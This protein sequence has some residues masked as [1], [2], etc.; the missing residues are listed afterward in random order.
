MTPLYVINDTHC[1]AIRS[2]GTTPATAYALRT[3]ILERFQRLLARARG[4]HLMILGDLFDN[5]SVPYPDLLEVYLMLQDFEGPLILVPGNHDLSK[6]TAT[7]S[8][9][10]FLCRLLENRPETT[11]MD[12]PGTLRVG[13][14]DHYVIPHVPN[15]ELFDLELS[16]VPK[17][18][19][20]LFLH[21]NF[22]NKFA[23]QADH[24]LNLS[25]EQAKALPVEKIILA[26]EHQRKT[27]LS[28]KVMIPGNQ[29]PSSV[30]D[31]L[32][33]DQKFMIEIEDGFRMVPVWDAAG[34]FVRADWHDLV[35]V[36]PNAQFIRVEGQ[37]SASEAASTV[38]LIQKLRS[39]HKAFVITNAI[40]V[41]GRDSTEEKLTLEEIRSYNVLDALLKRLKPEWQTKVRKLMENNDV[42][43]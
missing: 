7:M 43:R 30:A 36:D 25:V 32:G 4:G 8:S 20:Y 23:Q 26:H 15:Q 37:A 33:N 39:S 11:V 24:S 35:N 2:G 29:I 12:T 19:K 5:F 22:D 13:K 27:A 40:K 9:F 17:G 16:R 1:G 31:C 28:G 6:T 3:Y 42:S 34:S 21:C 38:T 14:V 10:Q 41:E 18:V